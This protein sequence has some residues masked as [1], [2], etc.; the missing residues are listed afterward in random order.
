MISKACAVIPFLSSLFVLTSVLAQ[1]APLFHFA[2]APGPQV[3]LKVLEQYD[4]ARTCRSSVDVLGKP[5]PGGRARPLRT[6]VWYPAEK[7]NAD[8]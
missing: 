8:G 1:D 2:E 7:S 3:G 6:L 5:Y 4:Y